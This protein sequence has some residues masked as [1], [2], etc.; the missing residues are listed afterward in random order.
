MG[1]AIGGAALAGGAR[2]HRG[3]G[4]ELVDLRR[5]LVSHGVADLPPNEVDADARSFT[6]TLALPQGATTVH[7]GDGTAGPYP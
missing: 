4:D 3:A 7:V 2:A 6:T 5:T 1:A